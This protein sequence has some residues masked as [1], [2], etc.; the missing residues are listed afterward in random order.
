M[1]ALIKTDVIG[2]VRSLGR[3]PKDREELIIAERV[4]S[5]TLTFEGV[6]GD[7]HIG[8]TRA[9]CVRVKDRH[10]RGTEIRNERQI[11]LVSAE[12]LAEVAAEL[13]LNELDE[14]WLGANI[15]VEGIPD[16][17]HLPPASRL[18]GPS[19]VTLTV[20]LQNRP[21]SVVSRT[22][23]AA[24]NSD[25]DESQERADEKIRFKSAAQGRRGVT[26]YVERPGI[27]RVGDELS[28]FIPNQRP[29]R[30]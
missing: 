19:G 15:V 2:V 11:S 7:Y 23:E 3:S 18:Q 22:I 17:S 10:P 4:E 24:R 1:A 13:N 21:C 16:L 26:L 5:L 8:A 14:R 27:L 28:L 12:E 6:E 9:A 20:D 25:Q 29:W 30:I